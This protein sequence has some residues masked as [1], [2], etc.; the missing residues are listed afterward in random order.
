M[1]N[2]MN[3][4]LIDNYIKFPTAKVVW[5]AIATMYFDG[6]YT[7]QVCDLKRRVMRLKQGRGSIETYY[8]NI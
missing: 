2:S 8:N 6:T 5:D 1:I 7:S 3:P 4:K